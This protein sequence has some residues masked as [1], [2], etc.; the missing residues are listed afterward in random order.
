MQQR[1]VVLMDSDEG[2]FELVRNSLTR[3]GFDVQ[4]TEA[5]NDAFQKVRKLKPDL[6]VIAVDLPDKA[7]FALC[8]RAKARAKGVP[9]IL[10]TRTIPPAEIALHQK[11]KVHA[12]EYLDKRTLTRKEFLKK[13]DA[14]VGLGSA[15]FEETEGLTG[16]GDEPDLGE[17]EVLAE[18]VGGEA[19][20][21]A[22][23]PRVTADPPAEPVAE[24]EEDDLEALLASLHPES[25]DGTAE[26]ADEE[27][28]DSEPPASV[29]DLRAEIDSLR[30]ELDEAGQQASSSPPA[31]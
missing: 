31:R 26:I 17:V 21:G 8:T 16:G 22:L 11:L 25:G 29:E 24:A 28:G 9:V 10:A 12:D 4:V 27:G 6:I 5:A 20:D 14:L 7:G 3:Y 19:D 13:V 2:F 18:D 15:Q 1:R 30:Q 23:S